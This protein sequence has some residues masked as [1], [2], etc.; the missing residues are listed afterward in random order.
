[1]TLPGRSMTKVPSSPD[2]ASPIVVAV[3][4]LDGHRDV[5]HGDRRLL[6]AV[7]DAAEDGDGVVIGR[8]DER[9]PDRAV[10]FAWGAGLCRCCQAEES[11]GVSARAMRRM[12]LVQ[13]KSGS[14]VAS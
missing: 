7:A 8:L 11:Q 9:A 6:A 14:P 10:L 2:V 13:G 5:G 1:M 12:V 3:G 4:V